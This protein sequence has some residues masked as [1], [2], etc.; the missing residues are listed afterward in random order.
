MRADGSEFCR[1]TRPNVRG[2]IVDRTS[3]VPL[4]IQL[5]QLISRLIADGELE[6]GHRLP[7]EFE[8]CE[9][10]GIS[11]TPVRRALGRLVARELIK[12]H[13]GRGTF[14]SADAW[15]AEKLRAAEDLSIV[16]PDERWCWP[17][18]Q[19]AA[20]WNEEHP[21]RPVRLRFRIIGPVQLREQIARSVAEGAAS[22]ISVADSVWVAEFADRG[23][24]HALS[25]IDPDLTA[26]V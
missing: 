7:T 16:V 18:Q 22:D 10:L 19:A 5:E 1:A 13:P 21:A 14:V 6:P 3:P 11:R 12:R 17:L 15:T 26:S 2:L 9:Q 25:S 23:Y 4:A 24:V 8:L 20:L